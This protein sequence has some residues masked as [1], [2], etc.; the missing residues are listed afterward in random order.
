MN[1]RIL[2]IEDTQQI[3]EEIADALK[4]RGYQVDMAISGLEGLKLAREHKPNLIILDVVMP[5]GIDGHEVC[6]QLEADP[7]THSILVL[8][9]TIRGKTEE[10]V[11]GLKCADDY[12]TKPFKMAELYARI[13]ALLR[14]SVHLPYDSS[15]R[16]WGVSLLC[17]PEHPIDIRVSGGA[18]LQSSATQGLL[19]LEAD[20]L[21]RTTNEIPG[22]GWRFRAKQLGNQLYQKIFLE[23]AEVLS[24]YQLAL[25][26]AGRE[27]RRLYLSFETS[28][29]LLRAPFE[30]L[31]DNSDQGGMALVLRHPLSRFIRGIWTKTPPMSPNFLN[32]IVAKPGE[33]LKILII[34]SNTEPNI[35]GVDLEAAALAHELSGLFRNVPTQVKV[36]QTEHATYNAVKQELRQSGY[37]IVHYAGHGT[38]HAGSPESSY[39]SFWENENRQGKM[40]RMPVTELQMLLRNSD[41][42][43]IY[44]SCCWGAMTGA[45]A[46][47]LDH[48]FLGVMD[49]IIHA[50]VPAV[51]GFRWPVSDS[52]AREMALIFYKS[53]AQQGEIHKALLEARSELYARNPDDITWISPILIMQEHL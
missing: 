42:R 4:H 37:H 12:M 38:Y 33:K 27:D 50:G 28:R 7:A 45:P 8:M 52:S 22:P 25:G 30:F 3:A 11:Q 2:I 13:D 39:L 20:A 49:G 35:P 47:L 18:V 19:H 14:R 1:E 43:F 34:S 9:L 46:T 31:M 21:S 51:L 29:H 40:I 15:Q 23:H 53:L 16:H 44:L 41:V 10:V 48:D 32:D 5:P 36:L 24:N 17:A 26:A 6:R